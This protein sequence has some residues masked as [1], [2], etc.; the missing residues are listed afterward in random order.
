[1]TIYFLIL[2]FP[3]LVPW[4]TKFVWP[5]TIGW[6]E[7]AISF[8]VGMVTMMLV[9]F[10][11]IIGQTTDVEIWNGSVTSKEREE[12]SCS[13]S[14]DCNCR[15]VK[16][17]TGSGKDRSCSNDRV[18]DT[19]YEHSHDYDWLVHS[20][21]GKFEIDRIDSQ[22]IKQPPRWSEVKVGDPVAERHTFTNYVK[23]VP[24]SLFHAHAVNKFENMI[25][26]YPNQ[27]YDYYKLNRLLTVNV[28]VPD[29]SEWNRDIAMM[30]RR[31]GP[32]KQANVIVVMVNTPDQSYVHAL[33][34]RWI[35]GKKNDIIVV[36]GVTAYPKIDWVA[37]SSW[38]DKA[39]FK[40]QL[41]D[42]ILDIG[43]IDR[44]KII[45]AID[46]HTMSTF[47]RKQMADFEYLKH[48]IEP[49]VW[50]VI[51]AIVLSMGASFGVSYYIVNQSP[52]SQRG[53]RKY[54]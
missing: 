52:L 31:L 29:A 28:N 1:M 33:E 13:H 3:M 51:L 22:G 23:A 44:P 42:A 35:G 48:Q 34:G 47:K 40:V 37:I 41:R 10:A 7:M 14:Y 38:T 2:V 36:I 26:A 50:V 9:Y 21:L 6:Q 43:T 53:T 49:P 5:R 18:C 46:S 25:P 12:V 54:R 19:C 20:D 8:G 11:G 30:L 32:H 16:S 39:L 15:T 17:C 4:L 27:V 24:D 45:A